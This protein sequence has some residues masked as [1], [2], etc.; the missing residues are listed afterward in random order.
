M[1]SD[2][3]TLLYGIGEDEHNRLTVPQPFELAGAAERVDQIVRTCI[4]EPPD[5]QLRPIPTEA[6]PA[7][8]YLV[9][10]VPAAALNDDPRAAARKP[11]L[12]LTRAIT[13]ERYDPFSD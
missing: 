5:V 2:G 6:D 7:V 1:A 10:I 3:G 12:P 9:V 13:G 11:V 4:S 8:G